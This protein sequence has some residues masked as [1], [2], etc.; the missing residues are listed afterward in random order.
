MVVA[1]LGP[2]SPSDNNNSIEEIGT[3]ATLQFVDKVRNKYE[4]SEKDWTQLS[5]KCSK[6]KRSQSQQLWA[7]AVGHKRPKTMVNPISTTQ[8]PAAQSSTVQIN[9]LNTQS[10]ENEKRL[11]LMQKEIN[12]LKLHIKKQNV[13]E[14]EIAKKTQEP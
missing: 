5:E 6:Q 4:V 14:E 11:D 12:E 13:Q 1:T 3:I 8:V 2:I 7:A 10:Q 9:L